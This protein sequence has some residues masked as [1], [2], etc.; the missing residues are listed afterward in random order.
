MA[1]YEFL[2]HSM[3]GKENIRHEHQESSSAIVA[4]PL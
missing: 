4:P 2:L 1:K 3:S